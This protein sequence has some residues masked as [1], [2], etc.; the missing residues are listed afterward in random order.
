MPVRE[1]INML[2]MDG[3]ATP[4]NNRDAVV[5]AFEYR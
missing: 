2:V 1:A 5:T 4:P 3:L